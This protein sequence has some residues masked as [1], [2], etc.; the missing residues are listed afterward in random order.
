MRGMQQQLG[1]LGTISAFACRH[2]ETNVVTVK[3]DMLGRM[4]CKANYTWRVYRIV[5]GVQLVILCVYYFLTDLHANS[6]KL[7]SLRTCGEELEHCEDVVL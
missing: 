2:R 1:N 7:M 3:W 5:K 4:W 6:R